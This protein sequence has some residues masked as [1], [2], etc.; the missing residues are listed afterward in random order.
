SKVR[1][2][3]VHNQGVDQAEAG[4]RTA[5]NF[6]GLDRA[7]V[8]RGDVVALPGSLVPSYMLDIGFEYLPG[9]SKPLKN[10]TRVRFH[11]GTS[12]V[13]GVLALLDCE[14]LAPGERTI[15]QIRLE[16]PLSV[17]RDDRFVTRS[18]SPV[19]TIG[20]GAILNPVAPKHK[21]LTPQNLADLKILEG[22][23]LEGIIAL[24]LQAAGY[25]GLTFSTL[26]VMTNLTEKN[27]TAILQNMMSRREII[28]TDKERRVFI[29]AAKYGQLERELQACLQAYH[30]AYPL[31]SG[32]S[33]E[34][35][36][37]KFPLLGDGKLF[38]L[39]LNQ[40]VRDNRVVQEENSVRLVKHQ[41]SLGIDQT[42]ARRQIMT[43]Y[44]E[45]GLSP[46]YFRELVRT[47]D[48]NSQQARDVLLLL[49]EEKALI[50]A[51]EDLYFDAQSISNLKE[52]LV[53]FLAAQGEITTP[54]F[55]EMTGVSR[56]YV[57]PLIEYF[58]SQNVTLR[59]GDVRRLRKA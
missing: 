38:V 47:L 28:Q 21:G 13:L 11:T 23:D 18:Y 50:K 37:S 55:K 43:A 9:N 7:G 24:H 49:V 46:P 35:L 19:Y 58:D 41:V 40:L 4:Q 59:I 57:I 30:Q 36:R 25:G 27:L 20:G 6:Q 32:M 45:G 51:K 31:K 56:K 8:I 39:V 14:E 3:Q 33:K 42:E 2:L 48:L 52:K 22:D 26:K 15:A 54:Q 10:R 12:E 44:T 1:G 16:R 17:V 5:I 53:E 34:E 29:H